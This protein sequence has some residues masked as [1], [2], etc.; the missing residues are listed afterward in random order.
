V[1]TPETAND[2][3]TDLRKLLLLDGLDPAD[4]HVVARY[5]DPSTNAFLRRNEVRK[6]E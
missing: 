4:G 1:A 6:L 3:A 2:M 5:N